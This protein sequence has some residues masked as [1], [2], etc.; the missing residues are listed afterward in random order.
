MFPCICLFTFF[1]S[2]K[3]Q[4]KIFKPVLVR[5]D[6]FSTFAVFSVTIVVFL[7]Q[8]VVF[9]LYILFLI[10]R[11][12]IQNFLNNAAKICPSQKY[13]LIF[14]YCCIKNSSVIAFVFLLTEA[15][16]YFGS[17]NV[18]LSTFFVMIIYTYPF[19]M[20]FAFASFTKAVECFFSSILRE[21]RDKLN[22][23]IK[24]TDKKHL[25]YCENLSVK[26]KEIHDLSNQF[27]DTFGLIVTCFVTLGSSLTVFNVI[28]C[29]G[30]RS[31]MIK[32][33]FSRLSMSFS[34]PQK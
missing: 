10:K 34:T 6:S 16:Q 30:K 7:H 8:V 32:Y 28:N 1:T 33:F 4:A 26:Y 5:L 31:H 14:K 3:Y 18:N 15:V 9:S 11:H 25:K 20:I 17:F 12:A 13:F 21:F 29:D 2:M 19:V 23:K 22:E 27:N 24:S